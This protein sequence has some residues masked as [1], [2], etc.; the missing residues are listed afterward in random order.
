VDVRI[1]RTDFHVGIGSEVKNDIG[2]FE[3]PDPPVLGKILLYKVEL[4]VREIGLDEL[5]PAA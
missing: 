2:A 5:Q 4:V 3:L 1:V